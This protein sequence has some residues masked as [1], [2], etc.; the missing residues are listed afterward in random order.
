MSGLNVLFQMQNSYHLV[1]FQGAINDNRGRE[2]LSTADVVDKR[3]MVYCSYDTH[4]Q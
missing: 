1:E 2:K 4:I 3:C